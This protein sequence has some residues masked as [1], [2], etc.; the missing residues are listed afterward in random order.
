MGNGSPERRLAAIVAIDVVGYSRLMGADEVGTLRILKAHQ[1]IL[2]PMV[3]EHGGRLVSTAGDGLLLEFP[4][5]VE[6]LECS[7]KI[8][9]IMEERNAGI[10]DDKQ[11]LF[12][13][14]INL[15]DII[16]H[17]DN[18]V[19]GDGVNVAARIE[20]L[21]PPGGICLSRTVR[22]HVRDRMSVNL[23]DMG[24]I[25]VK[26]I[27]RPIRVF[28]VLKDGETAAKP[29]RKTPAWQKFAAIAAVVVVLIAGGAGWWW[30]QQPDFEPA[31]QTK[32]AFSI[33]DK[34]S[35][36]VLPFD[37]LTGDESQEYLSDGLTEN[38]I[39]VLASTPDLFVIARNSSFTYKGKATKVQNV[40]EDLGV[41]YVL[42]GSIQ[43]SGDRIRVTAQL[44]DA[45]NGKHLW[46]ERY[47]RPLTD[48]LKIQDEI[49]SELM[50]QMQVHLTVGRSAVPVAESF[51]DNLPGLKK[52]WQALQRFQTFS[53][54]GH[55]D[56]EKLYQ[57]LLTELPNNKE[58]IRML[59]WI[60]WQKIRL[61]LTKN[62]G[63]TIK[64]AREYAEA[65]LA[66]E[67]DKESAY[68]PHT[69]FATLDLFERKHDSAIV[70]ADR[71]LKS[72]PST[73]QEI[74]LVGW[75]KASSGQPEEGVKILQQ[76]MRIEPDYAGWIPL[77]VQYHL[78]AMERY[79]EAKVV[80]NGVLASV[81]NDVRSRKSTLYILAA[82]SVF[83]ND[84]EQAKNLIAEI[85][86]AN[87]KE[88]I[89]DLQKQLYYIQDQENVQRYLDALR[90]AGVP[91][92]PP[93]KAP[94]K[95]SIAVLPFANLSDD[96]DQE[97]FADGMTD[98][99]ITD[100]SKI[101]GLDV[102]A[103]NSVF[104]YKGKNV[105]VQEVARDLNVS[106]VLE[107]S[108]RRAG[109]KIRINAQLID[110][111]TGA[112]L[113]AETFDRDYQ[114]I[115]ALQDEVTSKITQALKIN[116]TAIE[117]AKLATR[118]TDNIEAYE[119][120]LK[121]REA[122]FSFEN[123]AMPKALEYYAQAVELD[124]TY[125]DA[126]AAE[127]ELVTNIWRFS[128]FN[129]IN[130]VDAQQRMEKALARA[131]KYDP[132]NSIA[133]ITQARILRTEGYSDKAI[134]LLKKIT[135]NEPND[136]TAYYELG[137]TL[138][139]QND[140]D[141][142]MAY[143]S[144]AQRLDPSPNANILLLS[145]YVYL[146]NKE[147]EKALSVFTR[148]REKTKNSVWGLSGSI[149][150]NGYLGD[151]ISAKTGFNEWYKAWPAYS[152]KYVETNIVFW[153]EAARN[154]FLEGLRRA[155]VPVWPHAYV[156]DEAQRLTTAEIES[157]IIG[158]KTTG[159]TKTMGK[160]E[161][162]FKTPD[163]WTFESAY[164][165]TGGVLSVENDTLCQF[166]DGAPRNFKFCSP[167]YRNPGGTKEAQNEYVM[168]NNYEIYY[169]SIAD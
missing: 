57:E 1:D 41:R 43:Q 31:D 166:T 153:S 18:D 107:G 78:M 139:L 49:A 92:S 138:A 25:E 38:I 34:P 164:V 105:K 67:K 152:Q 61:Q 15:G 103:R 116:L 65:A 62:P 123:A 54:K 148:G 128:L 22:N 145:G 52:Y 11:M 108:V 154:T 101:S 119:L 156:G 50:T 93:V 95:P 21:A 81:N 53:K 102:I 40:A 146:L 48:F 133:L 46:A 5:V 91:E 130:P 90:L 77:S 135:E 161:N 28:R 47:D 142:A 169:F 149:A 60:Q 7:I 118:S 163:R 117:Q 59:G 140:A 8:Q 158:Q 115:F 99:L 80:A 79:D 94:D 16:I 167:I 75:V 159:T 14:G 98:D 155:G 84:V 109:G 113:W 32:Y 9:A 100:L 136:A 35:I 24:E 26:N 82:I 27:A 141:A 37:N 114:D 89:S 55:F 129:V 36:A 3:V 44:V 56:A 125:A 131:L 42:E 33:P 64:K 143:I 68:G 58:V 86:K 13:I 134:S 45:L 147:Y 74:G 104:T 39:A 71:V 162:N 97:Y 76:T 112:H 17:T 20:Q 85:L 144:R 88:N 96:K 23:E 66:L 51:G 29:A 165:N 19:F 168:P 10:A 160:Y 110:A 63:K 124:P 72:A 83:E 151:V 12:R 69:L 70:H 111:A 87:P 157:E 6:A 126:Y 132:D 137:F 106:H 150:A 122:Y 4:S 120:F 73:A 127:A 121:G 2:T 30:S